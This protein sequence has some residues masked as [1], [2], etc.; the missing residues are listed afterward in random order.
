MRIYAQRIALAS[1]ALMGADH[2]VHAGPVPIPSDVAVELLAV[3]SAQLHAGDRIT[4]TVSA[5]NNGPEPTTELA[6]DSSPI[7]DELELAGFTTDCHGQFVV[8]VVDL[9]N[10]FYYLLNWFPDD[11]ALAV[12]ETIT[13]HVSM[14]YTQWAPPTFAFSYS[15]SGYL[16]DLDSSNNTSTVFLQRAAPPPPAP[17]PTLSIGWL[18]AL[19][20]SLA[21]GARRILCTTK[22]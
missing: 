1:C 10:S 15:L 7:Y 14:D 6:F 11:Q 13:C 2:W 8:A 22:G 20:M 19:V 18:A 4:F 12:G 16:S 17:V 9:E 5:T 3:P 21:V